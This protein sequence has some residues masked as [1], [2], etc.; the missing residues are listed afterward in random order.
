MAQI[1][2]FEYAYDP[3]SPDV[4]SVTEYDIASGTVIKKGANR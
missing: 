1:G 4:P 3:T 2:T